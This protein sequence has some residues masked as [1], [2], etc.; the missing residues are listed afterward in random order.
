MKRLLVTLSALAS[1]VS[2]CESRTVTTSSVKA[3]ALLEA[4]LSERPDNASCLAFEKPQLDTAV[5]L[6]RFTGHDFSE[7]VGFQQSPHSK[8]FYAIGRTGKIH[9][10]TDSGAKTLFLDVASQINAKP[11]EGGLLGMAWHPTKKNE[12]YLSYTVTSAS[13]PV[14]LK[15]VVARFQANDELSA[16]GKPEVLI[17]LD[18]PFE[19]H[20]GGYISFGND[21]LLYIAF[22]DG[23]SG[24]DP[25]NNGQNLGTLAG[26]I[27]RL[28]VNSP[29]GYKIPQDNP[30]VGRAGARAEIY[31]YGLRNPWRF[32]FDRATGDLWAG[33]VGQDRFEEVNKIEKGGNYGWKVKEGNSCF[34]NN[35][36]CGT[37]NVIDPVVIYGRDQGA[38]ITGGFVYRGNLVPSLKGVYV[39]GDFMSGNIWG[40]FP[41]QNGKLQQKLLIATG[42]NIPAF[43]Q[44][45]DGEM[46]V[47]EYGRGYIHRLVPKDNAGVATT[48]PKLLSE[49]GCFEKD[50]VS[51]PTKGLIPYGVNSPL[52]S[53]AAAKRRWMALP[54]N[55]TISIQDNGRFNFPNGTVLVK[56]FALGTQII[57]TRLFVKHK[58][59]A[60]GGYTYAWKDDGSDAELV[61]NGKSKTFGDLVWNYPSTAQCLQ[62][63]TANAGYALGL[64]V[65]QLNG[66]VG[67]ENNQWTQIDNFRDIGLFSS[68]IP[69][70]S[71]QLPTPSPTVDAGEGARAYLHANC[72]FCHRPGGT[73]GGNL[74]MRYETELKNTG[75]CNAPGSGNLGITDARVIFPGSPEKS[76]LY[77]RMSRRGAQQMPPLASNLVDELAQTLVKDWISGLQECPTTKPIPPATNELKD[78]DEFSLEARHSGKCL[79]L[80]NG[81]LANG[82]KI[83]QWTCDQGGN[84]RFRAEEVIEGVFRLRNIKTNK[85]LD[86]AGVSND[87]DAYVQQWECGGGLNQ[88][89]RLKKTNEGAAS[90]RF[91]HSGKC[92]DVVDFNPDNTARIIQY[93][94]TEAANQDWFIRR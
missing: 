31:A 76:V 19:N 29:G 63:H 39:F 56:E 4:P 1:L 55:E 66:K 34:E 89:V 37:V 8:R 26:K 28:D 51:E 87:N 65:S 5:K 17:E 49:T 41:D 43:G 68:A 18:K 32:Q 38:S 13:S 23:G 72:A 7:I 36:G 3:E 54:N 50:K 60:W 11:G 64:E 70:G 67:P 62:C 14:N 33:D 16:I 92:M 69:S 44:D 86:I 90:I 82:A 77:Q 61:E 40:L 46:Y 45:S 75:L 21:G 53:D 78:G 9:T 27:L 58:D 22:G 91:M 79:D 42:F 15:S 80:D 94:C 85:C 52:W 10:F 83:H 30:F 93:E 74:D 71:A 24:G 2:A 88:Q 25:R 84:Q 20:N 35:P 57:E 47:L 12:F 81:N 59:G 73:G 6:Q 48:A